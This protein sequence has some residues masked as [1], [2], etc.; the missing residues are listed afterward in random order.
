MWNGG[1]YLFSSSGRFS[2]PQPTA[3]SRG[4]DVDDIYE[5][6]YDDNDKNCNDDCDKNHND[7]YD[8]VYAAMAESLGGA[9]KEI[10]QVK[11]KILIL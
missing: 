6:D 5:K 3:Q 10:H 1:W 7:D 2:D 4:S 9:W 11:I 8:Q